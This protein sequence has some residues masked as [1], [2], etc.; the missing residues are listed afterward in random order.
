MKQKMY[1]FSVFKVEV[2]D[3]K[4]ALLDEH[5]FLTKT[6]MRN[7]TKRM[8]IDVI[9]FLPLRSFAMVVCGRR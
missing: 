8:D 7:R 9:R 3:Y 5:P 1:G 2:A 6:T 4:T